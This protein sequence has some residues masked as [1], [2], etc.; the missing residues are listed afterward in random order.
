MDTRRATR[1]RI[2][3]QPPRISTESTRITKRRD[4]QTLPF[5]RTQR[6][7]DFVA[8]LIRKRG[9][10]CQNRHCQ[11]S[12]VMTRIFADHIVEIRDGGELFDET[13]I[14]LLC[15]SC[16]SKKTLQVRGERSR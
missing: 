3:Q 5:Y 8:M 16:H 13:N 4:K 2:R 11:R 1:P 6:W 7:K 10:Q 12:G 15:G 9:R 14:Q